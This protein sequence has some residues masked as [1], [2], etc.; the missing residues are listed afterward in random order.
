MQAFFVQ[1]AHR[2]SSKRWCTMNQTSI[3]KLLTS[4]KPF[5][6]GWQAEIPRRYGTLF[7]QA[8]ALTAETQPIPESNPPP[9]ISPE[10]TELIGSVLANLPS[11]LK[12]VEREFDNYI[13][14]DPEERKAIQRP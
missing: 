14:N 6:Y 1:V 7:G 13:N 11:V 2:D 3:N 9:A 12:E 8:V 4:L 10:E 5:P